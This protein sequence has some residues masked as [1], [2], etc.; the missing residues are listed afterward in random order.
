MANEAKE[1]F[2]ETPSQKFGPLRRLSPYKISGDAACVYIRYSK[3][4]NKVR[5]YLRD[6]ATELYVARAGRFNVDA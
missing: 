1:P 5:V 3:V 2:L 6:D 4:H